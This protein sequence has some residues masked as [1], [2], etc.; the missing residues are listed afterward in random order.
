MSVR[1]GLIRNCVVSK[2]GA[3][4]PQGPV[5]IGIQDSDGIVISNCTSI[6]NVA[7]VAGDKGG[8]FELSAG[9]TNSIIENCVSGNNGQFGYL[10]SAAPNSGFNAGGAS[11]NIVIRN[12]V[13]TGDGFISLIEALGVSGS[14]AKVSNVTFVNMTVTV[15]AGASTY[16]QFGSSSFS[17]LGLFGAFS[18][19]I[20]QGVNF[21]FPQ[22]SFDGDLSCASTQTPA[23]ISV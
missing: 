19:I 9:T 11:S 15:E 17:G 1:G 6:S 22:T 21:L 7:A 18:S 16:N 14:G 23:C 12:S 5:G 10:V 20:T 2:N 4:S 8:G 13:S 3:L